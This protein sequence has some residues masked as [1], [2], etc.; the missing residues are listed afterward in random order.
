MTETTKTAEELLELTPAQQKAWRKM[1]SGAKEFL[2]AGGRFYSC[3][4]T[5]SAYNGK[6][7]HDIEA[8]TKGDCQADTSGMPFFTNAGLSS[9]A[10][11]DA[12]VFFNDKG[13]K[14]LG[15]KS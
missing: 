3:L 4:D 5:L 12:G 6:Y 1:E 7:V 15:K 10:D 8:G 9:F 14:L 2:K 13:L 11:D